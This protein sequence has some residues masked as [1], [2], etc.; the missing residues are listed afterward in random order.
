ME[1]PDE[2]RHLTVLFSDLV[3]S[4]ELASR[5]DPEDLHDVIDAYQRTVASVV[6]VHGGVIAQFQGDGVVAYFGYPEALESAGR[7]AVTA[8]L[9][10][11]SAVRRLTRDL[12]AELGLA[13]LQARVGI[14]TGEVVVAS[15]NVG[16][17]R[18]I[19]DVFGEVPN[20]AA[21]LQAVGAPGE[22][23][24]SDVTASL[25]TGYFV[26]ESIGALTLKGISREVPA[27]RVQ[28]RSAARRRL[29]TGPL[30]GFV[31]RPR[32]S[33]WL[34]EHWDSVQEGP[35]RAV[36][37]SGEPGIGKSRLLQEF[38]GALSSSGA[39]IAPMYCGRRDALSPLRPFGPLMGEVPVAP[40]QAAHWVME[41]AAAGP[42][43]LLVEDAHWADPSTI[44]VIDQVAHSEHPVLEVLTARPEFG[45]DPLMRTP[46]RLDLDRLRP[47]DALAVVAG[48]PGGEQLPERVRQALVDRA[49]GVPLYLEEL[50]RAVVEGTAD[51]NAGAGIPPTLSEVIAARLDRLG[52]AKRIAQLAAIIGRSFDRPIL[53]AVSGLDAPSLDAQLQYLVDQAV[54][55]VPTS[56]DG[57]WW[58]RHALI[59][60]AAYGSVLRTDRRRAHSAVADQLV[61][62]QLGE[63]HPEAVAYHLGAAGRAPEA[64]ESWR[65]AARAARLNARFREAAGHER[66]LLELVPHLPKDEQE[67]VEIEARS[68]LTLCLTAVDQ[69]SPEAMEEGLRVQELARRTGDRRSLLRSLLVLLPWWQANAD[70]GAI[71]EY[72]PEA[73]QLAVEL[74]DA[75]SEQILAQFAG[76]FR[77]WQGRVPEGIELL[78]ASFEA[79]G[80]PVSTSLA[81]LPH[82]SLPVVEIVASSTR[83]LAALGYWLTGRVTEANWVRRDTLQFAT[84]RAVP[85][86]EAVT[87][88]TAA[89]MA[90]FDGD[91]EL[92][93]ELTSATTDLP[94]DVANRQWRQWGA[95]LRWWAGVDMEEP[96]VPGP[97]LR[98]YFLMLLANHETMPP[99][100]ALG[101]LGEALDT[102]RRTGEEFCLPEIL[103]V[104]AE[105]M[106]RAGDIPAARANLET[107][108]TSARDFGMRMLL[109]R[110][111]TDLV[112]LPDTAPE[113]RAELAALVEELSD[114]DATLSM[115][116]AREALAAS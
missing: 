37:V 83:I 88:A 70:Y 63:S 109:L 9:D 104:R 29:E 94:D 99:G 77:V 64:V 85:Q 87:A 69:N 108:V 79:V 38:V 58:F 100:R 53:Q 57:R 106:A 112:R 21:R 115:A 23:I 22:V 41:R 45:E 74:D 18:K 40:D 103:R 56:A 1:L 28:R 11:V 111:L 65:R 105:V 67:T 55:E 16:V 107:A 5:L 15:T 12:P 54:M 34:H 76:A 47:E 91:R 20:L 92:V 61:L 24:V 17:A 46:Y 19:G 14:H 97:L 30:T 10:L 39:P 6:E 44:E 84:D 49:D 43:L 7:D 68:R 62:A 89:I 59:H 52:P 48:V 82:Q 102:V 110:S 33:A 66:E 3:G 32:E 26:M 113:H 60:E 51:P 27:Y 8:G 95:A 71:A 86:A 96:E 98:P 4:T 2:R 75:I 90:Q 73:Q 31:A 81:G 25:V 116:R 35:A 114:Q 42:L 36:L 50:T 13:E 72:L 101:M 80:L 93:I 78:E